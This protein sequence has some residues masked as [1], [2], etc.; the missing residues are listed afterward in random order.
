[1]PRIA[2]SL[3]AMKSATRRSLTLGGVFLGAVATAMLTATPAAAA[4]THYGDV[5][6]YNP[7][8]GIGACGQWHGDNEL[9]AA[10][11]PQ[12]YGSYPNPN[13]SP[14]CGRTLWVYGPNSLDGV[15][16]KV[17][18]RCARCAANDVDLSPAAFSRL[19]DL[20]VGRFKTY[21]IEYN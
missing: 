14:V 1:M 6:W 12:V 21:W 16:V 20:G 2:K 7:S 10:V 4:T 9:V 5:T 8:V 17:V 11:S 15:A 3:K 19:A 13:N 18:D